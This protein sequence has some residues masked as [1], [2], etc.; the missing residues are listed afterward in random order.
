MF[1]IMRRLIFTITVLEIVA[2]PNFFNREVAF[3]KWL[4]TI[5][6]VAV[7]M[8]CSS[9]APALSKYDAFEHAEKRLVGVLPIGNA[10]GEDRFTDLFA[11]LSG[12]YINELKNTG[13]YR[14]IER[15]KL[16]SVLKE[17]ALAA[18]GVIDVAT[19]TEIGKV[20][21]V[22]AV[23]ISS[24]SKVTYRK[25]LLF[26]LIAWIRKKSVEVTMDARVVDITTAEVLSTASTVVEAWDRKWIALFI[27]RLGGKNSREQL[28][29]QAVEYAVRK[30]ANQLGADA[31]KISP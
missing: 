23:V 2:L 17:H 22:D 10:T 11:S 28:E 19:A 5:C 31:V 7:M 20:L 6:I 29:A 25:G 4:F 14:V 8:R 26:G 27:F 1:P 9:T 16:S 12:N 21:G 24:I 30:T 15:E 18:S 3:M 13:R